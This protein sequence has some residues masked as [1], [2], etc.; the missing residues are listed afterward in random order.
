MHRLIEVKTW[1]QPVPPNI[2]NKMF[3][4]GVT[5]LRRCCEGRLWG[6]GH[7]SLVNGCWQIR[8][9]MD[10]DQP[11]MDK[12]TTGLSPWNLQIDNW[13][14]KHLKLEQTAL[15]PALL[16]WHFRHFIVYMSWFVFSCVTRWHGDTFT[17]SADLIAMHGLLRGAIKIRI[18]HDTKWD[19][20]H[21]ESHTNNHIQLYNHDHM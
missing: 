21:I 17:V 9:S 4:I 14:Q 15:V 2:L 1:A 12:K 19:S 5:S 3:T 18:Q 8:S 11:H 7:H 10:C 16:S 20:H 6:Y 13:K